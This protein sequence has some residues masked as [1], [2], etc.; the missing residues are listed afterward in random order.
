M[1]RLVEKGSWARPLK[2]LLKLYDNLALLCHP[3]PL[4]EVRKLAYPALV[5]GRFQENQGCCGFC[6]TA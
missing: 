6:P 1:T 3:I 4:L 2:E 5:G